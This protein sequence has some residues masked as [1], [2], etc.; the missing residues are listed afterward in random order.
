M[1]DQHSP[2]EAKLVICQL[3][4]ESLEQDGRYN[5]HVENESAPVSLQLEHQSAQH[6]SPSSLQLNMTTTASSASLTVDTAFGG[7]FTVIGDEVPARVVHEEAKD[8]QG[9]VR[10]MELDGN[11]GDKMARGKVFWNSPAP[12]LDR[13]SSEVRV[14]TTGAGEASLVVLGD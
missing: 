2:I 12:P 10:Y 13:P 9:G 7:F 1:R 3:D 11:S 4:L 8:T 14:S 6:G 5:V